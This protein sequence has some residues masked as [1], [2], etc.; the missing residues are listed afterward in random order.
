MQTTKLINNLCSF[1]SMP[2]HKNNWFPIKI[3]IRLV[4]AIIRKFY[5]KQKLNTFKFESHKFNDMIFWVIVN[6]VSRCKTR[7]MDINSLY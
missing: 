6:L 7:N 3:T 1:S 5:V 2:K 4:I